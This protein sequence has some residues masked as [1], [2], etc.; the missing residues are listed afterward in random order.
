MLIGKLIVWIIVGAIA[1]T[2]AGRLLT[3]SKQGLGQ[4]MNLGVGMLG[5]LI[6]G[7]I[8]W[9]LGIDL[10]LGELSISFEDLIAAFAG[11]VLCIIAWKLFHRR[12]PA[13]EKPH[14]KEP[15]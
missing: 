1:G 5:A 8:F 9:L 15:P 11:S 14:E 4:W 6:G 7:G 10:G 13:K 12:R 2:L 3:F